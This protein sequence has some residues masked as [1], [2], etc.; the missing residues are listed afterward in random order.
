MPAV[1]AVMVGPVAL[2][3]WLVAMEQCSGMPYR[4]VLAVTSR[5]GGSTNIF[6]RGG[7]NSCTKL[8]LVD[9]HGGRITTDHIVPTDADSG[10][11][12]HHEWGQSVDVF[13]RIISVLVPANGMVVDPF[14]GGGTTL[15]A[16]VA[17]RRSAIGVEVDPEHVAACRTRLGIS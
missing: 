9:G 7:V 6:G 11:K 15:E 1:V 5:G 8:V 17:E 13:S 10:G 3:R 14:C 12:E 4:W 16:A 2:N